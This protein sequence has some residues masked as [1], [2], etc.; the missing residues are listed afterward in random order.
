MIYILKKPLTVAFLGIIFLFGFLIGYD[1]EG[2][3]LA[4][5]SFR[6][7]IPTVRYMVLMIIL[8]IDCLV[9][10]SLNS[11][12]ILFRNK[13]LLDFFKNVMKQEIK[14]VMIFSF[15][16]FVPILFLNLSKVIDYASYFILIFLNFVVIVFFLIT[17]IRII[18]IWVNKRTLSTIIGFISFVAIDYFTQEIIFNS[19]FQ[20]P[21]TLN[22]IFILP[23][24]L[25]L[26]IY[27][28]LL[29]VLIIATLMLSILSILQM[30]KKDYLI[31]NDEI[32][33]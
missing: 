14:V 2:D 11:S 29:F 26:S 9:F 24:K 10:R 6:I 15:F 1:L 32:I 8:Y 25:P 3:F 23:L 19:Q 13:S 21:I 18:D 4:Y 22:D 7:T 5:F 33:E 28:L 20:N 16:L 30:S 27:A 12:M 31:K 17:V